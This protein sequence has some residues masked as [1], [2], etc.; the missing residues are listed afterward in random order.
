M[1][2]PNSNY[3]LIKRPDL[4]STALINGGGLIARDLLRWQTKLN[5]LHESRALL[6]LPTVC[7]GHDD[8]YPSQQQILP[9]EYDTNFFRVT[10]LRARGKDSSSEMPSEM[11]QPPSERAS[12]SIKIAEKLFFHKSAAKV[13]VPFWAPTLCL[14]FFEFSLFFFFSYFVRTCWVFLLTICCVFWDDFFCAKIF[15]IF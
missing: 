5:S 14:L 8:F 1:K 9:L 13:S 2:P 11:T 12:A 15:F 4:N 3:I 6:R 10:G 7:Q